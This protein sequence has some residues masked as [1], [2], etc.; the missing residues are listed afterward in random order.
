MFDGITPL[1][2]VRLVLIL[3]G[4]GLFLYGVS[5]DNAT[6]REAALDVLVAGFLLRLA[7]RRQ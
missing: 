3:L 7:G 5:V 2:F 1:T 4:S 6:L